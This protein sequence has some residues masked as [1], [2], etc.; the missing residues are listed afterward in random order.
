MICTK[1]LVSPTIVTLRL[2]AAICTVLLVPNFLPTNAQL[3]QQVQEES[4]G[5][6]TAA[7]NGNRFTIG[8]TIIVN[9]TVEEW[10]PGSFVSI[11]I[12]DPLSKRVGHGFPPVDTYNTFTYSFTAGMQEGLDFNEP[13]VMNGT[14]RIVAT[15]F[16]PADE[17]V[18]EEVEL[19]FEF[20]PDPTTPE[21][22]TT[23]VDSTPGSE[24]QEVISSSGNQQQPVQNETTILFQNTNDSFRVQVPA[25]WSIED[26]NNTGTALIEEEIQGYGILAHLCP[27]EHDQQQ[28]PAT[29]DFRGND[30]TRCER[31]E[32]EIIHII[33]YLDLDSRLQLTYGVTSNTIIMDYVLLYHLH[34]LQEVG[35]RDIH[36]LNITD[37][38]TV[39]VTDVQTNQTMAI[40]P[41]KTVEIIYSTSFA[42]DEIRRGHFILT[43]TNATD[44]SPGKTKGYS[45]FYEG[46]SSNSTALFAEEIQAP[47]R[48]TSVTPSG[49][50]I[51][52]SPP[53][54]V[55]QI[56]D[57]FELIAA[58][59]I[60]EEQIMGATQIDRIE[61]LYENYHLEA[62]DGVTLQEEE[63]MDQTECHQS[64]PDVCIPPP[65]PDLYCEDISARNFE[66][67]SPDLHG[68][69]EDNDGIGCENDMS[70]QPEGT[71]VE[72]GDDGN[73]ENGWCSTTRCIVDAVRNL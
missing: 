6:L 68:F 8:D 48:P 29:N 30:T 23:V 67:L 53:P 33:R 1:L 36:V 9:G 21:P 44:P 10:E 73:G 59:E 42:P 34:K 17:P 27:P 49:I 40:L 14:Y 2:A 13:M 47:L 56:F 19:V 51:L 28:L 46:V 64:Y 5:G 52:P 72:S 41:T 24:S 57:S 65:P 15:Y 25:D 69:D 31:S 62:L 35:Y 18:I 60:T 70:S 38:I 54:A 58:E 71:V 55:W 50:S 20:D 22:T 61:Q 3:Q 4:D 32:N 45:V 43:A 11:V 16:P 39:N 37:T 7:L 12:I 63:E 26:V 66:V